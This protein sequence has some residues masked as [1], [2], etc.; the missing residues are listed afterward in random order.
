MT[1]SELV[2]ALGFILI[3]T[4]TPGPNNITSAAM[5][6]L[7]GYRRTLPYLAGITAGFFVVMLAC[8]FAAGT[9][10][11]TFPQLE[12]ALRL[13]SVAYTLYLAYGVLHI[14]R[15]TDATPAA[16][17]TFW[18]GALLQVL[19][20]KLLLYGLTLFSTYFAVVAA[21]PV[22]L[23][24]AMPL[25]LLNCFVALS[26]WT[27]F[28]TVFRRVLNTPR[29]R[30]IFNVGLALFLVYSAFELVRTA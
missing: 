3:S 29:T 8:A 9:V 5:G 14:G 18:H 20:V 10:L 16:L 27:L 2:A 22:W 17:L 19:N 30:V 4:Y 28:G 23:A 21:Q 25:L 12:T 1:G 24:A 6:A 26:A 7:H 15:P 11:R 13:G